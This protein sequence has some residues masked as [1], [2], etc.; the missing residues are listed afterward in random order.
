[1]EQVIY[2]IG[3]SM[4]IRSNYISNYN[5]M[6]M[7]KASKVICSVW[8]RRKHQRK[9]I[10]RPFL[11]FASI[12][13]LV[14]S[15]ALSVTWSIAKIFSSHPIG[16]CWRLLNNCMATILLQIQFY[17]VKC[18]D[19]VSADLKIVWSFRRSF[20]KHKRYS[21]N[22]SRVIHELN[23]VLMS[24]RQFPDRQNLV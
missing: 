18:V 12:Q 16:H 17:P 23:D 22:V 20:Q 2:K 3:F 13:H 11:I 19:H 15:A 4:C 7:C 8:L 1:M 9:F 10:E 5:S 21:N 24:R 6:A 14:D